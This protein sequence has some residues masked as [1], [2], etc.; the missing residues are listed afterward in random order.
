MNGELGKNQKKKVKKK[1]RRNRSNPRTKMQKNKIKK[2]NLSKMPFSSV[3]LTWNTMQT[4]AATI[5]HQ[6]QFHKDQV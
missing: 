4:I 2:M 5:S 3:N 1:K 6:F